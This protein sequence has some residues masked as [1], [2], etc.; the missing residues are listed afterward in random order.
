M[1]IYHLN[2]GIILVFFIAL[3]LVSCREDQREYVK[4]EP[5]TVEHIEGSE[6]SKV[7]LTEKAV[8]RLGVKSEAIRAEKTDDTSATAVLIAPYSSILYDIKG[9]SWVYTVPSPRVYL[10]EQVII[11]RIVGDKVYLQEGPRP[12]TSI[13]TQG[14]S[15]L[16]GTEHEVGH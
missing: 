12:G 8:E 1:K 15:E 14:A 3:S 4:I 7:T 10:R 16:L 9:R 13:V 2:I 11:D 5:A 6:L